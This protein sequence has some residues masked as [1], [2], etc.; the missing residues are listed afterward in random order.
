M[1]FVQV[2]EGTNDVELVIKCVLWWQQ[3]LAHDPTFIPRTLDEGLSNVESPSNVE[4]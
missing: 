1:T 2:G 3:E 4:R